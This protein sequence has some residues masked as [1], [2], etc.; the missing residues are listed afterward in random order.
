MQQKRL[1]A[2]LKALN[3]DYPLAVQTQLLDY[4]QL[5][6]KWNRVYNLTAVRDPA[7][8]VTR[9]LLDSF[10][11]L[12]YL[13]GNRILDVGTGAGLPGIPLAI[14]SGKVNPG[15]EFVLLDS[16]SKKTRFVQQVIA[17][18]GLDNVR[19]VHA[20]TE[21]FQSEDERLAVKFDTVL[22]RAF[23]T[24]ADMLSGAGQHCAAT[25]V[26]LAMKGADPS[27]ELVDLDAAYVVQQVCRLMV[28]GLDE[29]RHVVCLVPSK[30]MGQKQTIQ[31]E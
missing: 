27:D 7:E 31:N 20:R 9:H 29:E 30:N 13:R 14:V 16:N 6:S 8:M 4:V 19:V 23:A 2:G 21:A 5:L 24:V 22:S 10:S 28:P 1:S 15:R 18:L 3:L 17:E 12:P 11:V 26:I 25:G